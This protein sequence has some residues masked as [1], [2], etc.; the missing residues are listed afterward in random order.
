MDG[1]PLRYRRV[2]GNFVLYSVGWDGIDHGGR[3]PRHDPGEPFESF[4]PYSASHEV[5]LVWPRP[6]A[7]D[8]VETWHQVQLAERQQRADEMEE[9]QAYARWHMTAVRQAEAARLLAERPKPIP[10]DLKYRGRFL[11]D[12][13]RNEAITG[14]DQQSLAQLL[15]LRQLV[16]GSEPEIITFEAPI[17]FDALTNI[18]RLD[19]LIDVC[20]NGDFDE[21]CYAGKA[22]CSRTVDGNCLITWSTLYEAPG[23]HALQLW[24]QLNE[25]TK[26]EDG[27]DGPMLPF[28]ITNLCQFSLESATYN[29]ESGAT[30]RAKLPEL[31]GK[32]TVELA[33]ATGEH[34]K[35]ISGTTSNG[36]VNVF[37]NLVD[38]RGLRFTGESFNSTFK[39]TLPDSKRSQTLNGP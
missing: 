38:D 25:P 12:V 8:E 1:N 18:G 37:W 9:L 2:A 13:L 39:I 31:N 15:T 28:T 19:L 22:E 4:T 6:A 34:L 32:F 10:E 21:G 16:T 3:M 7:T 30:L 5:D 14:T 33:T 27:L 20:T 24:L 29:P 23:L 26:V 11:V 17:R 36:V 35:T